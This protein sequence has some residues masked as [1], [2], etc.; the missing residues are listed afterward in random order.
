MQRIES[1]NPDQYEFWGVYQENSL[2]AYAEIRQMKD[3]INT[4]VLKF[5]PSFL[6]DY[7]SYALF[8]KLIE[9][10]LGK[11]EKRYITNGARSISH[12]SNIQYF[13]IEKFNFRKAY[14]K[15]NVCYRPILRHFIQLIYPFK[16]LTG[17]LT[18]WPFESLH[19][20]LTQEYIKRHS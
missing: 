6:T 18:I 9:Y 3:V 16:K 13:L 10:Y 15:L 12:D 17:K 7:T 14:C 4:S 20:L 19:A 1:L 5:H 11:C 2:V 8:Y